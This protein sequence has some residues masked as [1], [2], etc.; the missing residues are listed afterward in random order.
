MV[1]SMTSTHESV[2]FKR[3]VVRIS[4]LLNIIQAVLTWRN[5]QVPCLGRPG[6]DRM[7]SH[8]QIVLRDI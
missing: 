1:I 7:G 4:F 2:P 6:T 5:N 8:Y 3:S